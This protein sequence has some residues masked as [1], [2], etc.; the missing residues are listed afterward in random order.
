MIETKVKKTGVVSEPTSSGETKP[1]KDETME[2]LNSILKAIGGVSERLN[3]IE[4]R[5]VD[6]ETGGVNKFKDGAKPEDVATAIES[7]KGLDPKIS[8]IVDEML[9]V[10]FGAKVVG[11]GDRPGF[12][13]VI[14]VPQRLSDN[15]V[16]KRPVKELDT[17][18]NH[19]GKY[20]MDKFGNTVFEDYVPED[21]RSRI[22]SSS[23]SYDAVKS[24]CERVRGY[25]VTYFQKMAKPLPEFKVK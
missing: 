24:H 7:R 10:D 3:I 23:D 1:K 12:R 14:T 9:G 22:L 19:T 25:I 2:T 16:A 21:N 11:L 15:I 4:G 18:Q 5:V 17:E 8:E 13:F 20:V 6:I